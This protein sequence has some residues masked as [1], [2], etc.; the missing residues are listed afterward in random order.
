MHIFTF[1]SP[2]H[3]ALE[4][5]DNYGLQEADM[6]Q[7]DDIIGEVMKKLK[8]MGVDQT[9]SSLSLLIMA[10]KCSPGPTVATLRSGDKKAQSMKAVFARRP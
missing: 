3:K 4:G 9:R 10:P 7:F 1:L 8:D 5:K 6:A 2:K